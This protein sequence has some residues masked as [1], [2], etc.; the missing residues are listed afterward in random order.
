M[1]YLITIFSTLIITSA[2]WVGLTYKQIG[3]KTKSSQWIYEVYEL[4]DSLV[5]EIKRVKVVIASGSNSLFGINSEALEKAWKKP[6]INQS[7]HAGLG[8]QYILNRTK[9]ILKR[10][11]IVILP[12]EYNF[13]QGDGKP[14]EVYADFILSRDTNY[15]HSLSTIDKFMVISSIKTKRLFKGL[16]SP[17]NEDLEQT[18]GIYGVQNINIHRDQVNIESYRMTAVEKSA[19]EK[20][21]SSKIS[22]SKLSDYFMA[23]MDRYIS[24][25]QDNDICVIVMPP[26]YML[27][28]EYKDHKY[29]VFYTNIKL[30]FSNHSISHIGENLTYM[31]DK[32]YYFNTKYHL[33]SEGV[34]L[35]TKQIISDLGKSPKTLCENFDH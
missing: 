21:Y 23:T 1:N 31:Y 5:H 8:I 29:T 17:I 13:Y 15:F 18:T 3:Y 35:R 32:K 11:D 34:K 19:I 26:N 4:K 27:F 16:I 20:S 7:V 2:L 24:W 33:N 12:L 6:V 14:S 28:D 25:A 9:R 10:G 30:Y 22:T